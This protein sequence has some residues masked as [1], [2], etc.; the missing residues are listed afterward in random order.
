MW[1]PVEIELKRF[2]SHEDTFYSFIPHQTGLI[3]GVN[4]DEEGADSNGSGKSTILR[5]IQ[6]SLVGMTDRDLGADELIMN[7][8]KDCEL[9][10]LLKNLTTKGTLEIKRHYF[11]GSKPQQITIIENGEVNNNLT[12]APESEKR[13]IEL[14]GISKEDLLNYYLIDQDNSH[15]IFKATD[16]QQKAIISRF[17]NLNLV[18]QAVDTM[19]VESS[20]LS[21]KIEGLKVKIKTQEDQMTFLQ[22]QIDYH[23]DNWEEIKSNKLLGIEEKVSEL[24]RKVQQKSDK[25]AEIRLELEEVEKEINE[26]S[27]EKKD[28][29]RL[30]D[31]HKTFKE[32]YKSIQDKISDLEDDKVEKN[33]LLKSK[34]ECPKCGHKWLLADGEIDYDKAK[35]EL[36][37]IILSIE[38]SEK[39]RLLMN[40]TLKKIKVDADEAQETDDEIIRLQSKLDNSGEL[41]F[42]QESLMSQY[43]KQAKELS[44]E[45]S[46]INKQKESPE[47]NR[48][49]DEQEVSFIEYEKLSGELFELEEEMKEYDFWRVHFGLAGFKTFLVNKVLDN[50]EGNVNYFLKKFKVDLL[51]MIEG[52]K[53]LKSG[54]ISDKIDI[55]VSKNGQDWSKFK[56]FSGGQKERINV[57]GILTLQKLI[58]ST[59]ESGGLDFLGLDEYMENLDRIGQSEVLDLLKSSKT[60]TLVV[61]HMNNDISWDNQVCVDYRNGISKLRN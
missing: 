9:R 17:T 11:R 37:S 13:I 53:K 54:K 45:I 35:K 42:S 33:K 24:E 15:S 25:I 16:T 14:I 31:K 10:F 7:G 47:I 3:Y 2:I 46:D 49:K 28:V 55:L 29:G 48:L 50:I 6:V 60:T 23:T 56:K 1:I 51:V 57:C 5:A 21:V 44:T 20:D 59:S 8:C 40:T 4:H 36:N 34:V 19:E 32:K 58:N 30:K 22:E 41:I 26:L 38:S 18:D 27:G 52:Y 39:S 61:S 12:G 43:K